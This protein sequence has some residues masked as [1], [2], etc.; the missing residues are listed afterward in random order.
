M[1]RHTGTN[2]LEH[3]VM[4]QSNVGRVR[5]S[6]KSLVLEFP[7]CWHLCAIA[8][9]RCRA[10]LM[11]RLR[12][13]LE[14]AAMQ[15]ELV[16][17]VAYDRDR[18]WDSVSRAAAQDDRSGRG[19]PFL[20][21]SG[22]QSRP[23]KEVRCGM[24][25]ARGGGGGSAEHEQMLRRRPPRPQFWGSPRWPQFWSERSVCGSQGHA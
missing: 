4:T 11:P 19:G 25:A 12:R 6:F 10:E 7:E 13:S 8:Q 3:K 21:I 16:N 24:S 23:E 5:E 20:T 1:L 2:G 14:W 9:D 17:T 18:P 22:P 15:G